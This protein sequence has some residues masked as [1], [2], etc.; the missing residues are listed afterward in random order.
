MYLGRSESLFVNIGSRLG[1]KIF[2]YLKLLVVYDLLITKFNYYLKMI[3]IV[4]LA[5]VAYALSVRVE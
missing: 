2:K 4:F 1:F 5:L 3:V